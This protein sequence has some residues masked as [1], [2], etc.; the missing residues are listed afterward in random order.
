M[1]EILVRYLH[2][3]GIIFFSGTLIFEHLLIKTQMTNENFKRVCKID[4]FYGVSAILVFTAGMF[5]WFVFGKDASFYTSNPL[6]HIKLTLFFIV[7]LLSIFPT[8]YFIKNRKT[9]DEI[10]HVPKKIINFINIELALFILIPLLAT[11]IA[12]GY[13]L[14]E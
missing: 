11:L 13:G 5:L 14:G 1:E 12:R 10:V 3:V 8:I 2:F 9:E 6:F 4:I 7:G